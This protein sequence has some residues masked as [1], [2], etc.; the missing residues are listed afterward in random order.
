ML[1][2]Q[3]AQ[4]E[5]KLLDPQ[6]VGSAIADAVVGGWDSEVSSVYGFE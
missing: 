2:E 6:E 5:V 4:E 3:Q 1:T